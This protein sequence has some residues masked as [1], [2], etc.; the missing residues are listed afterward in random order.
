MAETEPKHVRADARR[1]YDALLA[2]AKDVFAR[3]G[4]DA[5]LE[6]ITQQAGVGRGTLYRHFPTR[7]HLFVA[8]MRER[9]E[10]L[11]RTARELL[12]ASDVSAALVD[13]LRLY[14]R[15]ATDYPGMSARVGGGLA[16]ENSPVAPL[17]GPMKDS[18]ARLFERARAEGRVRA[19]VSAVQVL[20]L[21][22]ALPT[23]THTGRTVSPYLEI[24]L[25]GLF[26]R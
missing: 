20:T 9:V 2:A 8:I 16:D 15:S 25:Y 7:E 12:D 5:P 6:A 10:E 18:F 21:V 14:D 26:D 13:W 23:D 17:C 22:G 1:N 3:L 24:V 4:T 11:D 19:D